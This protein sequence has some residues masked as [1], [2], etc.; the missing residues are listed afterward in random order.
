MIWNI[1]SRCHSS[2]PILEQMVDFHIHYCVLL[3]LQVEKSCI[4][5]LDYLATSYLP[6]NAE[7]ASDKPLVS[8]YG[9]PASEPAE[10]LHSNP[11]FEKK[12]IVCCYCFHGLCLQSMAETYFSQSF[13]V[14]SCFVH[15]S[16]LLSLL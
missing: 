5:C 15:R 4:A 10:C 2:L 13:S 1:Y 9:K 12:S 6:C 7:R 11:N 8:H 14:K 16:M 3:V